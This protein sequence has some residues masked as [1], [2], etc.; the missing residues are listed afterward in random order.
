MHCVPLEGSPGKCWFTSA[1]RIY[2]KCG[3]H[4]RCWKC[5]P[6]CSTYTWLVTVVLKNMGPI[7]RRCDNALTLS[8][9]REE[10]CEVLACFHVV[11][12]KY[13]YSL[14]ERVFIVKTY[15]ITGSIKNFQRRF[16]EQ[17]GGRNPPSKSLKPKEHC[18]ICMVEGGQKCRKIQCM[19]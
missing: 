14:E 13:R 8:V 10:T 16:V 7:I 1:C 11:V 18:W 5:P 3:C 17:F 6:V 15:W 19:T 9:S 4:R 2:M 12:K